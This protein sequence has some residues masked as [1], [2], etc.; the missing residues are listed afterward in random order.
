MVPVAAQVAVVAGARVVR[1]V[2]ADR[3]AVVG[4]VAPAVVTVVVAAMA[5]VAVRRSRSARG[6]ISSRT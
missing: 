6:R 2:V 3:A 5:A 1:V 4:L